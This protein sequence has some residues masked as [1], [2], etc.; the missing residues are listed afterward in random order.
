MINSHGF[1]ERRQL[2][3]ILGYAENYRFHGFG[4]QNSGV[5]RLS[6]VEF[7]AIHDAF[8]ASKSDITVVLERNRSLGGFGGSEGPLHKSLKEYIAANPEEALKESGLRTIAIEYPFATGDRIDVVLVDK[9]GRPATVEVEVDCDDSEVA[10]PLQCMKYRALIAYL[11]KWR[12][13]EVRTVLAA[14]S[15]A[16]SVQQRCRDYEIQVTEI[17]TW[18]GS[19]S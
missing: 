13:V 4:D 12:V 1:I 16:S 19:S 17:P 7:K 15:V 6:E 14:R 3:R 9:H 18:P 10:G 5:K 8:L 11:C 2:A